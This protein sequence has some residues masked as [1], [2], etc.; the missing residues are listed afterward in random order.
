MPTEDDN[1]PASTQPALAEPPLHMGPEF[2]VAEDVHEVISGEPVA[3]SSLWRDARRRLMKNKLAVLG[4]VVTILIVL[5]SLFGP[6]IIRRATGYTY[7]FIP[8]D[9]TLNKSFAPLFSSRAFKSMYLA[10]SLGER[11]SSTRRLLGIL[12]RAWVSYDSSG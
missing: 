3:G 2:A 7:D 1:Y 8:K 4:M 12:E 10:L 9:T 11:S 5:A 6:G